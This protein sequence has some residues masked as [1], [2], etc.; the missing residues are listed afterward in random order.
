VELVHYPKSQIR[1][2]DDQKKFIKKL[3][4]NIRALL[5]RKPNEDFLKQG[6]SQEEFDYTRRWCSWP[7]LANEYKTL[8]CV[9]AA[10]V[11]KHVMDKV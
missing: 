5:Y 3:S 4:D 10:M 6:K 9:F 11:S 7:D 8:N 2:L 1:S